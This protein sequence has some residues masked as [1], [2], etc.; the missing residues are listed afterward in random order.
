MELSEKIYTCETC[1]NYSKKIG[2]KMAEEFMSLSIERIIKAKIK[3]EDVKNYKSFFYATLLNVRSDYYNNNKHL[4]FV[5]E[6]QEREVKSYED[7]Y[8][9]ALDVFLKKE[10]KKEINRFYQDIVLISLHRTKGS[11][12][13]DAGIYEKKLNAYLKKANKLIEHE[14]NNLVNI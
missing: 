3:N 14:Y 13:E 11:I 6:Y 1:K 4:L 9:E 5:D 7:F 10:Y 12:C 2:G 8:K